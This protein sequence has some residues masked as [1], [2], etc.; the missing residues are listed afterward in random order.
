M[1]KGYYLLFEIAHCIKHPLRARVF[2][3]CAS[4]QQTCIIR[5]LCTRATNA[6]VSFPTG[7]NTVA[8]TR[9]LKSLAPLLAPD[10]FAQLAQHPVNVLQ[11]TFNIALHT[12]HARCCLCTDFL[13]G[14]QTVQTSFDQ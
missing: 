5:H 14:N 7:E 3:A 13:F 10:Q 6:Y 1:A 9:P 4:I 11:L 2:Y 8:L 12:V